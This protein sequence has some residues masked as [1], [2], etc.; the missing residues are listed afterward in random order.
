MRNAVNWFEIPVKDYNR[1]KQFYSTVMDSKIT[2]HPMPEQNIKYG[3]FEYDEDNNGVGGAIIE[4]EGQ[5]P[6]SDGATIYLNGGDDLS[7]ALEKVKA[8]GGKITMPKTDIG[9]FG[10]IAQ[11][12]DTEGNLVA[13][14]SIM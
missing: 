2:D 3:I 8:N 10:F 7:V 5:N 13:L 6:T 12:I 9:T 11:F 14:H 4:G 1:A